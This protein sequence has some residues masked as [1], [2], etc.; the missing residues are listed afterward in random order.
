MINYND[1]KETCKLFCFSGQEYDRYGFSRRHY[2]DM[3]E[4]DVDDDLLGTRAAEL[5]RQSQEI[6][7]K[8]KVCTR[9][10][11]LQRQ[12]SRLVLKSRSVDD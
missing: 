8:V 7:S 4:D 1:N 12:C 11:E 6:S 3:E 10:A 5:E 2:E 9:A